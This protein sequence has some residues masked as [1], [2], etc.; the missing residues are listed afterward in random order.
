MVSIS[1]R[2]KALIALESE[3]VLLYARARRVSNRQQ[4][5][6]ED[7]SRRMRELSND[8]HLILAKLAEIE[9]VSNQIALGD[10]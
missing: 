2:A 8:H 3:R 7:T 10:L 1:D 6:I 5:L 4:A 9:Y